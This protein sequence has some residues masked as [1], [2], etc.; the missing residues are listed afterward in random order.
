MSE[1]AFFIE[2]MT[3]V[4]LAIG[5]VLAVISNERIASLLPEY[6]HFIK[7]QL[8]QSILERVIP[9]HSVNHPAL[10]EEKQDGEARSHSKATI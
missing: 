6:K 9:K 5:M 10:I 7:G 8:T 2:L 4:M 3:P 1:V